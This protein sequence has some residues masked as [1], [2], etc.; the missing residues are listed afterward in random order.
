MINSLIFDGKIPYFIWIKR[1]ISLATF[2]ALYIFF[3]PHEF[4]ELGEIG[5]NL[6]IFVVF[7]RPISDLLPRLG[8]LKSLSMLRKELGIMSGVFL[9]THGLGYLLDEQLPLTSYF[10]DGSLWSLSNLY[11]WGSLGALALLLVLLTSNSF[12]I[13][14]LR[15][16]WKPIQRLTYLAFLAGAI[17][18]AMIEQEA[19]S[20]AIVAGFIILWALAAKKIVIWPKKTANS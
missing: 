16:W 12:A 11:G 1:L 17:H 5:W 3:A 9:I 6:L 7:I 4:K 14:K 15:T 10:T 8:I 18:I 13:K 2:G 19:G 20:I